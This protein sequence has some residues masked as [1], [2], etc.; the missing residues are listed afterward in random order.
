MNNTNNLPDTSGRTKP[1]Y[2][3]KELAM[4][5]FPDIMPESASRQL[6]RWIHRDPELYEELTRAGYIDRQRVFSPIQTTIL[7]NHLGDPHNWRLR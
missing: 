1:I 3:H 7:F 6:T 4:L 5:Y 2:G